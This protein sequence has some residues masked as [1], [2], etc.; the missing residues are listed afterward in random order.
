MTDTTLSPEGDTTTPVA[1]VAWGPE[2]PDWHRW[3]PEAH[4]IADDNE[5]CP[6]F[7]RI[8]NVMHGMPRPPRHAE[9]ER[10]TLRVYLDI[11]VTVG[12]EEDVDESEI[13]DRIYNL[14]RHDLRQAINDYSETERVEVD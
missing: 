13:A 4:E 1:F 3:W 10:V 11:D 14:D 6:E 8:V 7:D 2:H 9:H 5:M 12:Y